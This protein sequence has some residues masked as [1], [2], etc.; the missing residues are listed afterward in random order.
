VISC[1]RSR[2]PAF[3]A[4]HNDADAH[5]AIMGCFGDFRVTEPFPQSAGRSGGKTAT[6]P[7][8]RR[9]RIGVSR[10]PLEDA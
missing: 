9:E 7:T 1:V 8:P 2:F 3:T 4:S 5:V 10:C 6:N